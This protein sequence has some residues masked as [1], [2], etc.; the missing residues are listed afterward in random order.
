MPQV[1]ETHNKTMAY[2]EWHD[3]DFLDDA[4]SDNNYS[5]YAFTTRDE[6]KEEE[7]WSASTTSPGSKDIVKHH[8]RPNRS[9]TGWEAFI[10]AL[11]SRSM[12]QDCRAQ[13][14][15]ATENSLIL[16]SAF[17]D[18][19]FPEDGTQ[20]HGYEFM[21]D[22]QSRGT[23]LSLALRTLHCLV[24]GRADVDWALLKEGAKCYAE[25][26]FSL[27][28]DL[29]RPNVDP[30]CSIGAIHLF[31]RAEFFKALKVE[32]SSWRDHVFGTVCNIEAAKD[33]PLKPEARSHL[34]MNTKPLQ[35]GTSC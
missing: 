22:Y 12:K 13:Q 17:V 14:L 15:C 27:R 10:L 26:L 32:G 24:V 34:G 29:T 11:T 16:Q 9:L 1:K 28:K 7:Q 19:A 3:P 35:S 20:F 2:Q 23:T 33:I 4:T 31:Q 21:I 25:G 8:N 5:S 30:N 18:T 6:E